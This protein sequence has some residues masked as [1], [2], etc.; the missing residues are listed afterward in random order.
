MSSYTIYSFG[1]RI[2][3]RP[4]REMPWVDCRSIDNPHRPGRSEGSKVERVQ[5]HP[6]FLPLVYQLM[7]LI[8]EHGEAAAFCTWGRHRSVTVAEAA[9]GA[10][11][12]IDYNVSVVHLGRKQ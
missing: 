5:R 4:P 8:L 12:E 11:R 9:A 6:M 2:N 7:E 10:L 1:T 3:A